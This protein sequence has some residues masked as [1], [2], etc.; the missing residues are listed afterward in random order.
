MEATSHVVANIEDE[1]KVMLAEAMEKKVVA[2]E[3]ATAVAADKIVVET[4]TQKASVEA[5]KCQAMHD[6]MSV[7]KAD[8]EKDLEAAL[9]MVSKTEKNEKMKMTKNRLD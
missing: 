5:A 9:P 8:T 3:M 1:L 4:E 7:K 2:E 6:E